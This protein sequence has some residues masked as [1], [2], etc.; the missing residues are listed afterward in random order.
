M[1]VGLRVAL[2]C[3]HASRDEVNEFRRSGEGRE[4]GGDCGWNVLIWI[5]SWEGLESRWL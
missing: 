5:F 1:G 4:H 2:V 3:T